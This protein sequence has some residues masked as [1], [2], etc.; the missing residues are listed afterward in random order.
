MSKYGKLPVPGSLIYIGIALGIAIP[1]LL[2]IVFVYA[3]IA[4]FV[5]EN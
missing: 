4:Y 2:I 3:I 1:P 5:N